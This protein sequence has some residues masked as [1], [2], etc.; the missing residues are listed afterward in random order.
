MKC[1]RQSLVKTPIINTAVSNQ[2]IYYFM[3]TDH[4][5]TF[6]VRP[7]LYHKSY[8]IYYSLWLTEKLEL[9]ENKNLYNVITNKYGE[10]DS[11]N[12]YSYF[13]ENKFLDFFKSHKIDTP[14]CFNK[15]KSI[16]RPSNKLE[17]IKFN[18]YLMRQGKRWKFL[19]MFLKI[20]MDLFHKYYYFSEKKNTYFDWKSLFLFYNN[21]FLI[22]NNYHKYY[23]NKKLKLPFNTV[24][25]KEEK[26]YD[27]TFYIK[28]FLLKN[29]KKITPVFMYYIYK[30][31]KLIYKN[32][33]GKSGRHTYIWKYVSPYKRTNL[34][35]HWIM[36]ETKARP[37]KKL[38][39]RVY[40][41][42]K[43]LVF[44]PKNLLIYKVKR[45]SNIYVF[46]YSRNTLAE[47]YI[48]ST[49]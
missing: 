5:Q 31:A 32:T 48:T 13:Q 23:F 25:H 27:P 39:H 22:N 30:V 26:H 46:K 47:T 10:G 11:E 17:L 8:E 14:T 29:L 9:L 16:R 1:K 12:Y 24:I 18:N 34:V 36:K 15:T 45:F 21:L 2:P 7:H 38:K 37:G 3:K 6:L 40:S 42:L 19:K 20:M 4:Y 43:D 49:K 33:R 41:V 44:K 28:L 35:M